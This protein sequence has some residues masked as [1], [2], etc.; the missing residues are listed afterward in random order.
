VAP[1]EVTTRHLYLGVVPF[2]GL[3]VFAIG[4]IYMYPQI[5]LWLPKAIGW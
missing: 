2:I 4:L 1:P 5:A 3:Q